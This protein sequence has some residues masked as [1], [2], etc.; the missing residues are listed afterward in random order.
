MDLRRFQELYSAEAHEH[1]RLLQ[2]SL[3]A[4]E[5][6]ATGGA[7]DEAFRAA[8]TLKGISAAMGYGV[9]AAEAHRLEDRLSGLRNARGPADA[10]VIDELLRQADALAAAVDAALTGPPEPAPTADPA[11]EQRVGAA[12]PLLAPAGTE[13][14][15]HVHLHPHTP[16]R[17]ARA[18][19]VM[20]AV[21]GVRG[22]IG[23]DPATFEEEFSGELRV[24][25]G[26]GADLPSAEAAILGAGDVESVVMR[27]APAVPQRL[28]PA[29][30]GGAPKP[31]AAGSRQ[32]RVDA[33]L[34]DQ[35]VEQIGELSL[36]VSALQAESAGGAAADPVDRIAVSAGVLQQGLLQLRLVPLR[37]A[38]ERLP[39]VVRDAA[40]SVGKD[41]DL[42]VAGEDV[43]LDRS[44][45]AEL[46]EPLMH[47]LRNAVDHGIEERAG[48]LAAGKVE[49]GRIQLRAERE[50]SS[51]RIVIADDG[52]GVRADR[53]LERA[54]ALD[55]ETDDLPESPTGEQLFALLSRPGFSTAAEV[56]AV[57]GRGV[58]LDVVASRIRALGGAIEMQTQAGAGTTFNI[59]LPVTL[60]LAPALRV[61]V[62]AEQFFIPLTH[63]TE[64]VDLRGALEEGGRVRVRGEVLP[65]VRL[66]QLLGA[67]SSASEETAV[68]AGVG[69]RRVALGIDE[70]I[71]REQVLVKPIDGVRGLLPHFTG[72][73]F[74][75]SGMP[76]LVL[77]PLSLT[78]G[79]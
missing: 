72:A 8:H 59:R 57:S 40:R 18:F 30:A 54:R 11:D 37:D 14:I 47:L 35:L 2:R 33:E 3:L 22:L 21:A 71:G 1:V 60:S 79:T 52:G 66:G 29:A 49:R 73:A 23:S 28:A 4:L 15:A 44:I 25:F 58:G 45:V 42:T 43:Q 7:L 51:V 70:L 5:H 39:R 64:A 76:V 62:G 6:D 55:I 46:G 65:L 69:E 61:R 56:G 20:K 10:A 53:V 50:R 36:R 77:D 12:E 74:V 26:A 31:A 24:F 16:I 67:A 75:S 32:V 41:V 17:S 27:P 9:A 68:V 63:V 34:L 19:L 78:G 38:F 48:R 13:T